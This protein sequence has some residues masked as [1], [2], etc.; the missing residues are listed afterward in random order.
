M[1]GTSAC[2]LVCWVTSCTHAALPPPG[3]PCALQADRQQPRLPP[4]HLQRG[5]R[6]RQGGSICYAGASAATRGG[7]KAVR[8]APFFPTR[9]PFYTPLSRP[10]IHNH[11][12]G[13]A[14]QWDVWQAEA[15]PII[16]RIPS[17]YTPGNHEVQKSALVACA[18]CE[19]SVARTRCALCIRAS[20]SAAAPGMASAARRLK[21]LVG[22]AG[23][24]R[25]RGCAG[26]LPPTHCQVSLPAP[27]GSS[28]ALPPR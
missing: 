22:C 11:P 6:L 23:T 10:L 14:H 21:L 15:L 18:R 2:L 1:T 7:P 12:Q 13:E 3:V 5:H 24:R 27:H 17:I 16:S 26:T 4:V 19:C 9:R 8:F 25:V 20:W 28:S